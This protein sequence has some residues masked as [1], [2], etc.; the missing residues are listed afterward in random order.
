MRH[1]DRPKT[2][3]DTVRAALFPVYGLTD[4]LFDLSLLNHG[5]GISHLGNLVH[6]ELVFTS[7]RYFTSS[8]DY[9]YSPKRENFRVTSIDAAMESPEREFITLDVDDY[10]KDSFFDEGTGA[11]RTYQFSE[12][13]QRQAGGPMIWEGTLSIANVAF[14]GKMFH[15]RSPLRASAFL[16]KSEKAILCGNAYGPSDE[17]LMQLLEGLQIINHQDDVLRQYQHELE[18]PAL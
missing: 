3:F 7:P 13:E 10:F 4:H 5:V 1:E 11:L 16:L 8:L 17:E 18:N 6:V 2:I 15:W 14:V 9:L 12:E